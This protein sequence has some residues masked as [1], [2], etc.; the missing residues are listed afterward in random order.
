MFKRTGL[1]LMLAMA[2][3]PALL[4]AETLDGTQWEL[5]EKGTRFWSS[6]K[7]KFD[8]NQFTAQEF[9]KDGFYPTEYSASKSDERVSWSA[10]QSNSKGDKMEW[11]GVSMGD[12]M[13]GSYTLIKSNG[14]TSIHPW[15]A[16][17]IRP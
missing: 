2:F 5:R 3:M 1:A 12:R 8:Q 7:L 16:E 6:D 14:E 11:S 10:S 9:S 17:L 4:P 15:K 13:D